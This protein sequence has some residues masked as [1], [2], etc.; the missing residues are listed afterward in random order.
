MYIKLDPN[1]KFS[2]ALNRHTQA[3][4]FAVNKG[5]FIFLTDMP[6]LPQALGIRKVRYWQI[7]QV[8]RTPMG[9]A[10]IPVFA[11][12]QFSNVAMNTI[13]PMGSVQTFHDDCLAGLTIHS[14][15]TSTPT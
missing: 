1:I 12:P 11:F 10:K 4:E 3:Y 6:L 14:H 13:P 15:Y 5:I 8:G 7:T 2:Y 9:D